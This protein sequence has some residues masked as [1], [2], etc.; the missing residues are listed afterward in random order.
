MSQRIRKETG[1]RI[2]AMTFHKLGMNIITSVNGVKPNIT[3]ISLS[4]FIRYW[5]V[6]AG[7]PKAL[8]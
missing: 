3:Q 6:S 8:Q 4:A 2:D 7:I 5:G 1:E